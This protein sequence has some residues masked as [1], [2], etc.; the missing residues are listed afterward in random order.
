MLNKNYN[1]RL[2]RKFARLLKK[3]GAHFKFYGNQNSIVVY[4]IGLVLTADR[5]GN[6]LA[7]N[8]R[9]HE[10]QQLTYSFKANSIKE[11]LVKMLKFG[12]VG[13]DFASK[14]IE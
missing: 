7:K 11:L 3:K 5:E 2:I 4:E 8:I 1:E 12:L 6:F 13:P 10:Q 9:I 14:L